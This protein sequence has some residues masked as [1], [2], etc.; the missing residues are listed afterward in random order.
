MVGQSA[1]RVWTCLGHRRQPVVVIAL[2]VLLVLPALGSSLVADDFIHRIRLSPTLRF[3]GFD[4]PPLDLFVFGSGAPQQRRQLMEEGSF[5]WWTAEGFKMAF[6]RPLSVA[7]H[8]LDHWLWADSSVLMHAHSIVWFALLL[9]AVCALYRR[10]HTPGIAGLALLLYAFD[11]ARGMVLS[12]VANRNALIAAVFG[13]WALIVHDRWRRDGWQPGALLA[14]LLFGAA[15]LAGESA[16]AIA[17]YLFAYAVFMDSGT[18]RRRLASLAPYA[19]L[20]VVW[21]VVYR[22]LGYG[23]HA[24]GLYMHPADEPA[25]FLGALAVRLPILLL[26]Q[27]AGPP[28]DLW[29]AYS[30][31]VA[32]GVYAVA[33][34]C[35]AIAAALLWPLLRRSA[36][37]RFWTLGAVLAAVPI[38]A[39]FPSDRLLVFVGIGAMG[40]VASLL[41]SLRGDALSGTARRRTLARTV[42]AGI[43][44]VHLVI[45]PLLLPLRSLTVV[46]MGSVFARVDRSLPGSDQVRDKTVVI[47]AAPV[48]GLVSYVPI[49]RAARGVPR[50]RRL[51]LLTTGTA[52]VQ[53]TRLDAFTLRLRPE[54]GFYGTEIERM[55]RSLSQ[56][57]V[58]GYSVSL[59]DMRVTVTE[60]TRDGRAAEAEFRFAVPLEDPSLIWMR[61]EG[62]ALVAYDPPPPG[63]SR[64]TPPIDLTTAFLGRST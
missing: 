51:R 3:A 34:L 47:V 16:L 54:A 12:F 59:S 21:A 2:A 46:Q 24:S 22:T 31:P 4:D 32:V 28:S 27:I 5:A 50:P 9:A 19:L 38:C 52:A 11:D 62:D 45:A 42:A 1:K 49:W 56:P 26:A 60:V 39:T 25:R 10:F 37:T 33:L 14:P 44:G 63:T 7:T 57:V 64:P 8:V 41:T 18:T 35:L 61:W 6:W 29:L 17:G 36:V 13:V 20:T 53:V 58:P 40:T 55:L 30:H 48:D 43:V 15:L 23:T